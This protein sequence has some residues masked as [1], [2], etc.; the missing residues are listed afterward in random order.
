MSDERRPVIGVV[1]TA[2]G[3]SSSGTAEGFPGDGWTLKLPEHPDSV[4]Y[5][6]AVDKEQRELD[7]LR[8]DRDDLLEALERCV[9]EARTRIATQWGVGC[10]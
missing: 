6:K 2:A 9:A 10:L 3:S 1:V 8:K 5:R 7:Q 4:A